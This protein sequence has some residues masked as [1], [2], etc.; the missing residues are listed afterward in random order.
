MDVPVLVKQLEQQEL[1][2]PGGVATPEVYAK[3][4]VL[5]LLQNDLNNARYLWKRIPESVR[6]A[7]PD[8]G[9]I[10]AV[11]QKL[12]QRDYG[13]VYTHL[14]HDWSESIKDEMT[15]LTSVIKQRMFNLVCQAYS[16]I[17]A[18][19]FA[20]MVGMPVEKAI[21][22]VIAEGWEYN[23]SLKMILPKEQTIRQE[24]PLPSEQ[25]IIQL[26]DFVSFLEN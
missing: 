24:V 6:T 10:W 14:N 20:S 9:Q 15:E 2:S 18:D 3:L 12:W 25:Q 23:E 13:G 21:Q 4:M 17:E 11:G 8:L 26:T 5:Y 16:S 1:E 22:A 7:N 19:R